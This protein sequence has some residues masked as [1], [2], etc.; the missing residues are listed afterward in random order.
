MLV[1][2]SALLSFASVLSLAFVLT[3]SIPANTQQMPGPPYGARK[4]PPGPP[5]IATALIRQ[6]Q[7]DCTNSNVNANDSTRRGGTVWVYRNPNGNTD[8]TIAISA[9][10][11]TTYHFFLKCVRL[12]GDI[13]TYDEGE[14]MATFSFPTSSVGN[15]YAF[16][17][18]PEGAPP[19]NKFQSGQVKF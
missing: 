10:P 14:G 9:K 8:L 19:G 15:V 17:M 11:N 6:D 12:L 4:A 16:D 1:R 5:G 2:R 3:A 7:S 18:Y 13:K